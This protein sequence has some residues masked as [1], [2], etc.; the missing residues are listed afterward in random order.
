MLW[1]VAVLHRPFWKNSS[2][3]TRFLKC[4][5]RRTQRPGSRK[6]LCICLP[7]GLAVARKTGGWSRLS[8]LAES[9]RAASFLQYK[10]PNP[11]NTICKGSTT[12]LWLDT[13]L[14]FKVHFM[15]P[16]S[17]LPWAKWQSTTWQSS[18]HLAYGEGLSTPLK[19][20]SPLEHYLAMF[21]DSG[22]AFC[23]WE[24]SQ[25]PDLL[26]HFHLLFWSENNLSVS[27]LA[28]T[29]QALLLL[30]FFSSFP[31]YGHHLQEHWFSPFAFSADLQP[32]LGH[33]TFVNYFLGKLP[34]IG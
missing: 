30:L 31:P 16:L 9:H 17:S 5:R 24:V 29:K 10:V 23:L 8:P 14:L 28:Q 21:L 2:V 18:W 7:L 19:L 15:V 6:L 33:E 27:Q 22:K 4:R 32:F 34:P 26:L 12:C 25:A 1:N 20:R 11:A 3:W 13:F